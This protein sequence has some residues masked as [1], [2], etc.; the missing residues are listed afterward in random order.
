MIHNPSSFCF[1]VVLGLANFAYTYKVD[2]GLASDEHKTCIDALT[3][4]TKS[5]TYEGKL[6]FAALR[7]LQCVS[8]EADELFKEVAKMKDAD[9]SDWLYHRHFG[10]YLLV[11]KQDYAK[12][13]QSLE[14]AY[15]N[16][17]KKDPMTI[18]W[19]M[20]ALAKSGIFLFVFILKM[21]ATIIRKNGD[22]Y[23]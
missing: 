7:G 2:M 18:G 13:V 3:N 16:N 11:I 4:V 21:E 9:G 22:K 23:I 6:G 17:P 1:F 8:F 12:A 15:K 14:K 10:Q 5:L 19:Y 20:T